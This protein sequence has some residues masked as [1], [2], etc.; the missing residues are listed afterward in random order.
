MASRNDAAAA[1]GEAVAFRN[2]DTAVGDAAKRTSQRR[3]RARSDRA[4]CL[5]HRE[6]QAVEA[7]ASSVRFPNSNTEISCGLANKMPFRT[8]MARPAA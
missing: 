7:T 4:H 5:S 6:P 8:I 2:D 1:G 3:Q